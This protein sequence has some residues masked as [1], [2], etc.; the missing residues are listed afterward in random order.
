M[1]APSA[2]QQT[3]SRLLTRQLQGHEIGNAIVSALTQC[4][5][6]HRK[7]DTAEFAMDQLRPV[8]AQFVPSRAAMEDHKFLLP[9]MAPVVLNKL[10]PP[11]DA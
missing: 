4:R 2:S 11:S 8:L 6:R 10:R 9:M 3:I 1:S 5:K 7:K